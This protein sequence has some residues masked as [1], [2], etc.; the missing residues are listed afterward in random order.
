MTALFFSCLSFVFFFFPARL[1]IFLFPP[2][3]ASCQRKKKG[4][5]QKL[6]LQR[7]FFCFQCPCVLYLVLHSVR[8][9][10]ALSPFFFC[11]FHHNPAYCSS[12]Y[13]TRTHTH[14]HSL[15]RFSCHRGML[16]L[17]LPFF[18]AVKETKQQHPLFSCFLLSPLFFFSFTLSCVLKPCI[19]GYKP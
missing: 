17:S 19:R 16:G 11:H 9:D 4:Y 15:Y 10:A 18:C 7:F 1:T 8:C 3:Y 2:F 6:P 14:T 12:N 5:T 13:H